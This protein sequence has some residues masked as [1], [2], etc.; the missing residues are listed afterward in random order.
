VLVAVGTEPD[1]NPEPERNEIDIYEF[2]R[3]YQPAFPEDD[4][5]DIGGGHLS[6]ELD[7]LQME[8]P[9]ALARPAATQPNIEDL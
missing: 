6:E 5:S 4:S 9:Y 8:E 7:A 2:L 1:P 3:T